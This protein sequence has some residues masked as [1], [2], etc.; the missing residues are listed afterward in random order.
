M[1]D[2]EKEALEALRAWAGDNPPRPC[3]CGTPYANLY[4]A[5]LALLPC[6]HLELRLDDL[7]YV[8]IKCGEVVLPE[9][10]ESLR[11]RIRKVHSRQGRKVSSEFIGLA[12]NNLAGSYGL[13]RGVSCS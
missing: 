9:S 11:E 5:A 4:Y 2:K 10:D 12:L 6:K 7:D 8:C 1:N 13:S 3:G